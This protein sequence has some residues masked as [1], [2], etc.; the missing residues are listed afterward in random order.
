MMLTCDR[1]SLS[2][3]CTDE[4]VDVDM[5]ED[6]QG[7]RCLPCPSSRDW[8]HMLRQ[9]LMLQV[10]GD[11][12][13]WFSE[14]PGTDLQLLLHRDALN[15]LIWF[16][17]ILCSNQTGS[18]GDLGQMFVRWVHPP[19]HHRADSDSKCTRWNC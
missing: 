1:A 2:N 8:G 5:D 9:E 10:L 4:D 14:G 3:C 13:L 11:V 18:R 12:L 15:H 6:F 7:Q 19:D 17:I 16:G